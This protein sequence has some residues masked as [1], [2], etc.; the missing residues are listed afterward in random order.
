MPRPSGPTRCH[1][2]PDPSPRP[3]ARSTRP[4]TA[5]QLAAAA[6]ASLEAPFLAADA[7]ATLRTHREL[8][9]TRRDCRTAAERS[10]SLQAAA[11]VCG[12][13]WRL[14]RADRLAK[15]P[16][17]PA[18]GGIPPPPAPVTRLLRAGG[19]PAAVLAPL[20][21]RS[22][23]P[24]PVRPLPRRDPDPDGTV[25]G[26]L[27]RAAALA[28]RL[29]SVWSSTIDPLPGATPY[30]PQLRDG[31]SPLLAPMTWGA[32]TRTAD[33]DQ[34]H[35]DAL[36]AALAKEIRSGALR[37][38]TDPTQVRLITPVFLVDQGSK[39]RLVHDLRAG[40][41][42]WRDS[43][44]RYERVRD[45]LALGG[46]VASK[47]DIASAFKHVPVSAETA[48]H[49]C[50]AVDGIIFQWTRLP[51]GL[52]HSPAAFT[53]ALAPAIEE[54]R[55][56]G[57]RLVVYVDD[58]YVAEDDVA[59]LD[60]AVCDVVNT[61]QRH[62]WRVAPEKI[63]LHAYSR[64]P[65][66]GLVV[67]LTDGSL[68][69]AESKAAKLRD[70][71][72]DALRRERVPAHLLQRIVG[73]LSF[74]LEA[75]PTVGLHWRSLRGALVDA[76]AHPGRHVW[77]HGALHVE[78][79]FW[80]AN[81]VTLP[82]WPRPATGASV[83]SL[84]T[85]ASDDGTGAIA[86]ASAG[87]APDVEQWART[88][89]ASIPG[90]QVGAFALAEPDR[91]LSSGVRELVGGM[92]GLLMI[93]REVFADDPSFLQPRLRIL[94]VSDGDTPFS[95]S[96]P[97]ER[98]QLWHKCLADPE[99]TIAA[100]STNSP[101]PVVGRDAS[102]G[103]SRH[104]GRT[105]ISQHTQSRVCPHFPSDDTRGEPAANR[106]PP[107]SR[108]LR[109]SL[110]I[111]RWFCDSQCAVAAL[112]RWRSAA[113]GMN[114]AL[115]A[116]AVFAILFDA[117]IS[118]DWVSRDLGWIPAADFLSR[119]VG[120]ERQAEWGLPPSYALDLARAWLRA[121]PAADMFATRANRVTDRFRARYPEAGA[122]GDAFSSPWPARAWAFPP[123]SLASRA[124]AHWLRGPR[125]P[126]ILIL[127]AAAP[128]LARART[129]GVAARVQH[130]HA[131]LFGV[132]RRPAPRRARPP[133]V[134][135]LLMPRRPTPP[136]S[137]Q[138]TAPR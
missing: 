90:A 129:E 9:R 52:S 80:F 83:R 50:F 53:A 124:L 19:D 7:A 86:W 69:V 72:G 2:A 21:P 116:H 102:A 132:D 91:D 4:A 5:A 34:A 36:V 10:A 122:E 93:A 127:H 65:F 89:A 56:R 133:L 94:G 68:R 96:V 76:E 115:T 37:V 40:N 14:R 98:L 54:L 84:V 73:L 55:S 30:A 41:V 62:G 13:A 138:A 106:S 35:S 46:R 107:D 1:T 81:A 23:V 103:G 70:L 61:L 87:A 45:A 67:D 59:A 99:A 74:F 17:R 137:S 119:A 22:S 109:R 110:G 123:F 113:E 42:R 101:P 118:P 3:T 82:R 15:F 48:A 47:I 33:L 29:S 117:V 95:A 12:R 128:A 63:H 131:P 121:P 104:D 125:R 27:P 44:V 26:D 6:T 32:A 31:V 112:Q 120:R 97:A 71:C 126:A 49:L 18:T 51:F 100:A 105:D 28:S 20:F 114:A 38:V 25:V 60:D 79:S 130:V 64:C 43:T 16:L 8:L 134:A 58:V 66:L 92:N 11:A 75:V 57:R 85:D 24:D 111:I 88:R 135:V 39:W 77:R 136:P 78:L 108:D